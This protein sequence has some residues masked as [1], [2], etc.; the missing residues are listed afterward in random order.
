MKSRFSALPYLNGPL[1]TLYVTNK[2]RYERSGGRLLRAMES[3]RSVIDSDVYGTREREHLDLYVEILLPQGACSLLSAMVYRRG[4]AFCHLTL[5]RHG[6]GAQFRARDAK[7]L[8]I[9]LPALGLA[10]AGFQYSP[11]LSCLDGA[12]PALPL[13]AETRPLG[14]REAEVA[15]LVCKGMRNREIAMLVGTSC[16]TVKKQVHSVLAKV[17]VSNRTELAGLFAGTRRS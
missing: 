16:E 5:K 14:A 17:G 15:A 9:L 7:A 10:D 11:N 4:R 6:R 12:E 13:Y 8:D 3:G 2:V 1:R